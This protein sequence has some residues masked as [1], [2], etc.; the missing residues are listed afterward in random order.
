MC[1]DTTIPPR[2]ITISDDAY[3]ALAKIKGRKESFTEVILRVTSGRGNAIPLLKY[4]EQ[5]PA[6]ED[7]ARSIERVTERT[8]KVRL[9]KIALD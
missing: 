9:R 2:T 7:L 1:I 3:R 5:L 6:G 8:R 4:L